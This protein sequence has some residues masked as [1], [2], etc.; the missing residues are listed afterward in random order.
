MSKHSYHSIIPVIG[1]GLVC[2]LLFHRLEIFSGLTQITGDS[3][4]TRLVVFLYEHFWQVLQGKAHLFSPGMFYPVQ[5]TL[6]YA[7]AL[8]GYAP[9][10]VVFRALGILPYQAAIL[11]GMIWDVLSY[12]VATFL[13]FRVFKVRAIS[14]AVGGAL[15]AFSSAKLN[16]MNHHQLQPMTYLPLILILLHSVYRHHK[17]M[18][19]R[20]VFFRLVGAALLLDL[21]LV[22]G[23]YFGWFFVFW[24]VLFLIVMAWQMSWKYIS[25]QF[26]T[27]IKKYTKAIIGAGLVFGIGLIPFLMIYLPVVREFGQRS[28]HDAS[29]MTPGF[30]SFFWMGPDNWIWGWLDQASSDFSKLPLEWEHRVGLGIV[31][32][33]FW[34]TVTVSSFLFLKKKNLSRFWKDFFNSKERNLV[35]AVVL[36]TSLFILIGF[37]YFRLVSP[38]YLVHHLFPG[39]MGIRAVSRYVIFLMLPVA[40]VFAAWIDQKTKRT[41]WV[42]IW[43]L[44]AFLEQ[45][46]SFPGFSTQEDWARIVH[47]SSQVRSDCQSF[48]VR[49]SGSSRRQMHEIQTDAMLISAVS[50]VPTLN[51]YTGQLPRGWSLDPKSPEI[52]TQVRDWFK[53]RGLSDV[54][55][56]QSCE[57]WLD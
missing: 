39:A 32:S 41:S 22:S 20:S 30:L 24:L 16:Q 28:Y 48:F 46:G 31:L 10:Y 55:A 34:I 43:V 38:W 40:G 52:R 6:G 17:E 9:V 27:F 33:I 2:L 14:A 45:Q 51:G 3:G 50:G 36:S 4:D 13:I 11:N 29:L 37:N 7:D 12:L 35:P 15:Y 19:E 8:I 54:A 25:D 57:V 1:L 44:L 42:W 23:Y 47:L 18:S 49:A 56:D 21:Q 53:R 5:G 26:A